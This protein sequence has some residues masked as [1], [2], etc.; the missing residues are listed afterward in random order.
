MI[1]CTYSKELLKIEGINLSYGDKIILRDLHKSVSEIDREGSKGQV[2]S[3]LGQSGSGKTQLFR[4]MAGLPLPGTA[5]FTGT[6]KI[7]GE[8]HSVTPGEVGVV[9]QNYALFNHRTVISNLILAA[10]K[11]E[12]TTKEAHDKA[13]AYLEEFGLSDKAHLYPANLSGGQK[14]RVAIIQQI[15]CS[16]H[17]LLMDEPFSGLDM[18]MIEKTTSLIQKVANMD[19]LNTIII[20]THDITSAASVSDHLWLMGREKDTNSNFIPGARIVETYDLIQRDLCW[21]PDII[22]QPR[23]AEFVLEVKNR[24]REL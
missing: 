5:K 3:L 22:T 13:M 4:I 15:L 6:V 23:F 21:E 16:E 20:V 17:F 7:N 18:V 2:I 24:F 11:K 10:K 8:S 19:A 1:N 9:A 14:Q 12:K